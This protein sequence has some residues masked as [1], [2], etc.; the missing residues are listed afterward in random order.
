METILGLVALPFL[1]GL[2]LACTCQQV[3]LVRR[4]TG[5]WRL[6]AVLPLPGW[7]LWTFTFARDLAADPTSHN[8]FPFEIL[9]WAGLAS[10]Y[11]GVVALVRW[12]ARAPP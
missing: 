7:A 11:L 4:W 12:L 3:R 2:P 8:L 1:V 6:A 10:C 5:L 9:I